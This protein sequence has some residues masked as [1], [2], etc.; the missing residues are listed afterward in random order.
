LIEL[1]D[2]D[3]EHD[4]CFPES[5]DAEELNDDGWGFLLFVLCFFGEGRFLEWPSSPELSLIAC[6]VTLP[7]GLLVL[8]LKPEV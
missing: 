7:P 4:F 8:L 2:A 3:V 6:T 1:T 5:T